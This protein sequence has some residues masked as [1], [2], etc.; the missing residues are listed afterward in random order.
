MK[1]FTINDEDEA[2]IA[3]FKK[4]VE[5]KRL[6]E[7]KDNYQGASGGATQYVFIP[8]SLGMIVS[9]SHFGEELDLSHCEDW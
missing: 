9:V 7:G 5:A 2:A 4:Q 1:T 8:T 6:A 3:E